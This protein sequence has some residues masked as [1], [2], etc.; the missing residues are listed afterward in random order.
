MISSVRDIYHLT[1]EQVAGM[2]RMGELSAANLLDA[3]GKSRRTTLARFIYALGIR[4]VGEATAA[5]LADHFGDLDPLKQ[6]DPERLQ[7][8]PDVGPV[9]AQNIHVF[10]RQPHN[11]EVIDGLVKAGID[12]G[13]DD[14]FPNSPIVPRR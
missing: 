8:I 11:Q 14:R 6:A 9:I 3:I 12:V 13:G 1:K 10:F 7:G 5:T 2:E 4:G